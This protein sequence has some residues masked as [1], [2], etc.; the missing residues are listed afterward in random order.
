MKKSWGLT[1]KILKGEKTIET[2]WYRRRARPWDCVSKGDTVY[3][4]DSGESVSVKAV[5]ADVEQYE[6]LDEEKISGL[7]E[8]YGERDLGTTHISDEIK[9]YVRH[10]RYLVVIHLKSVRKVKPF[11]IDKKGFG[12]MSAW[13]CVGDIDSV[14][15]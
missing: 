13:L 3:F 12:M 14:K 11:D 9:D 4:K 8:R 7:L 15:T 2:R 1:Q 5:V 10:K 6:D